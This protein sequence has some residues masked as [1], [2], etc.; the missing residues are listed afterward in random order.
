MPLLQDYGIGSE[1][2][3]GTKDGSDIVRVR[4]LIEDDRKAA[5][6]WAIQQVFKCGRRERFGL[7]GNALMNR[8]LP[9][10]PT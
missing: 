6:G 3:G 8:V 2:G 9:H 7:E 10:S 5:A 1:G 4:Y